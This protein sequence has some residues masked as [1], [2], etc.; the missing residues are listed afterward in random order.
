M[1]RLYYTDLGRRVSCRCRA[2]TA[3]SGQSVTV[4][5]SPPV[6][7]FVHSRCALWPGCRRTLDGH[8]SAAS[9]HLH[10]RSAVTTT[11]NYYSTAWTV[12]VATC[13]TS[14]SSTSMQYIR[15]MPHTHTHTHTH[16]THTSIVDL[17]KS[18]ASNALC[19][20][21]KRE[22]ESFNNNNNN[23]QICIAP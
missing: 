18:K 19:T 5:S 1:I 6:T 13:G 15:P 14:G 3:V 7:S 22:K 4:T 20:P 17:Y 11:C 16:N 23:K 10:T 12:A 21:V 9:K 8:C 2:H